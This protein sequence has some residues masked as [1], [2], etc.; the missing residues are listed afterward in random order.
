MDYWT[1]GSTQIPLPDVAYPVAPTLSDAA[2]FHGS[3]SERPTSVNRKPYSRGY[4][5]NSALWGDRNLN[6]NGDP[7]ASLS[8]EPSSQAM[9]QG[10]SQFP[11]RERTALAATTTSLTRSEGGYG[12]GADASSSTKGERPRCWDHGCNGREFS[13]MSNYVR[14]AR[15]RAHANAKCTCPLC[16][17]IFTRRTARNTHLAKQSCNRIRRYSNGRPRPSLQAILDSHPGVFP[18]AA[19]EEATLWSGVLLTSEQCISDGEDGEAYD[20][21]SSPT[22]PVLAAVVTSLNS[23]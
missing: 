5:P 22:Q 12:L 15:E 6:H 23:R 10:T 3:C 21:Q 17:A 9:N 14:H 18:A 2:M 8:S 20:T 16:G 19:T 13:S 1:Y 7:D 4:E 11:P